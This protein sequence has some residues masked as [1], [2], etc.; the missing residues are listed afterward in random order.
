M[1]EMASDGA[2]RDDEE[3]VKDDRSNSDNEGETKGDAPV[4]EE[5]RR[6]EAEEAADV[7]MAGGAL[8]K[9]S[10]QRAAQL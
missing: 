3:N 8:T 2:S 7:L 5:A 10:E 4:R 6:N 9:T 1:V